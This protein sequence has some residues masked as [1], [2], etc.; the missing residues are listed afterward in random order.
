MRAEK[1]LTTEVQQT[2]EE[3]AEMAAKVD[4]MHAETT[5]KADKVEAKVDQVEAKVDAMNEEMNEKMDR[6]LALLERQAEAQRARV[7]AR[8]RTLRFVARRM[9]VRMCRSPLIARNV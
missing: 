2:K 1:M 7:C 3:V 5:E 8:E 9:N 4:A 6:L